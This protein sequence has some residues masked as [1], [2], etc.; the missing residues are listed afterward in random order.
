MES[1]DQYLFVYLGLL[2][3]WLVK[4]RGVLHGSNNTNTLSQFARD[5]GV[6]AAL[7]IISVLLITFGGAAEDFGLSLE[8]Y[9]SSFIAG[10]V[11]PSIITNVTAM[12]FRK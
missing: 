2:A 1:T 11:A 8:S 6:E 7:S 3:Y 5:Y 12:F 4:M 10:G 9:K